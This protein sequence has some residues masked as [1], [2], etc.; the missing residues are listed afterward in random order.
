MQVEYVGHQMAK[1]DKEHGFVA[2]EGSATSD[3]DGNANQNITQKTNSHFLKL[4]HYYPNLFNLY[5]VVE[6]A[7]SWICKGA[8]QVQIEKGEFTEFGHFTLFCRERQRYIP[9][10]KTQM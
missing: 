4:L 7:R 3:H 9:K 5:N 8:V 2:A 10:S 1:E 6:L